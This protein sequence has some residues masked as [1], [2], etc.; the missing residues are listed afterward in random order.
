MKSAGRSDLVQVI[1]TE[2]WQKAMVGIRSACLLL[3]DFTLK[4]PLPLLEL[5]LYIP[6]YR[7]KAVPLPQDVETVT[8]EK[9]ISSENWAVANKSACPQSP[10]DVF[11]KHCRRT[12]REAMRLFLPYK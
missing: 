4:I 1:Y 3:A 6:E 7:E 10:S 5:M 2:F 11:R 9:S 12:Q 8:L